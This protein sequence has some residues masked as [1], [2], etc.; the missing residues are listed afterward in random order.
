[1]LQKQCKANP[2]PQR[3]YII[4]ARTRTQISFIHPSI[5]LIRIGY[6]AGFLLTMQILSPLDEIDLIKE[7]IPC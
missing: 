2:F 4:H 3:F 6:C 5:V 7:D 1:M